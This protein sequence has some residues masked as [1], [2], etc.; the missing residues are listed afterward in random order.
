[1]VTQTHNHARTGRPLL[2]HTPKVRHFRGVYF[3]W[4]ITILEQTKWE[5]SVIMP[6]SGGG[7]GV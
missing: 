1:M 6:V 3:I 5:K 2:I 7:A 4:K